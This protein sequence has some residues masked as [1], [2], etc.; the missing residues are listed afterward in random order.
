[1]LLISKSLAILPSVSC[2]F[3]LSMVYSHRREI[4]LSYR[5]SSAKYSR[6]DT[7]CSL[8]DGCLNWNRTNDLTLIRGA[9]WPT[10]LWDNLVVMAGFEPTSFRLWVGCSTTELHNLGV[11]GWIRTTAPFRR[12]LQ[13]PAFGLSATLTLFGG[14]WRTRT[15]DSLIKS[16]IL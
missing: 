5:A 1:M 9:L 6:R 7:K 4:T 12:D 14:L 11:S 13:S 2:L 16:Q 10:E 3:Q 8:L 15:F